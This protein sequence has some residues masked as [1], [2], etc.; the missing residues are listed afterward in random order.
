MQ[1][2]AVYVDWLNKSQSMQIKRVEITFISF[3][4]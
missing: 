4:Y 3:F 1:L 2:I